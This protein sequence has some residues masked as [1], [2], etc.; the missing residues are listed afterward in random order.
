MDCSEIKYSELELRVLYFTVDMTRQ[1]QYCQGGASQTIATWTM[2]TDVVLQ[3]K[4]VVL[5]SFTED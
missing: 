2:T 4:H 3:R 1:I 5:T